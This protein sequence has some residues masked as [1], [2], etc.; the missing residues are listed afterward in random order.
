[1]AMEDQDKWV[2]RVLGV[3]IGEAGEAAES[4]AE[5][6]GGIEDEPVNDDDMAEIWNYA[7]AA[8]SNATERVD[9]QIGKLQAALRNSD[10]LE[11][12]DIAEFGMNGIT[13][14]TKVPLMAAIMDMNKGTR[15]TRR[16]AV[17]KLLQAIERFRTHMESD[18]RI[19]AC[20]GN[21][22]GVP[23]AIRTTYGSA[24]QQLESAAARL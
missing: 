15:E 4:E 12:Q 5:E 7:A 20:D 3:R 21:P 17:P 13:G 2:R 18:G 9:L 23:V 22:Y 10:D 19:E 1:M 16:A 11:L 6:P 8:F 24:L 14:N